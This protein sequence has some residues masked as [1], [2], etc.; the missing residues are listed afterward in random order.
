M[1]KKVTKIT[2]LSIKIFKALLVHG[3]Q[4]LGISHENSLNKVQV[5]S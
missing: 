1:K 3:H 5:V 2:N 4:M